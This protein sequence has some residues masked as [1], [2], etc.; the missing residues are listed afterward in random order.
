MR[1]SLILRVP[2]ILSLLLLPMALGAG[3]SFAEAAMGGVMAA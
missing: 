2:C 1:L 3:R